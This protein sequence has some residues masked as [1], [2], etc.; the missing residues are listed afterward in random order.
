MIKEKA[1][2]VYH[3]LIRNVSNEYS[4]IVPFIILWI[5]MPVS[6]HRKSCLVFSRSNFSW[7]MC[8]QYFAQIEKYKQLLSLLGPKWFTD[9]VT[10]LTLGSKKKK[11][12]HIFGYIGFKTNIFVPLINCKVVLNFW[13]SFVNNYT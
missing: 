4:L 7:Q 6:I 5:K 3:T 11:K 10:W 9:P 1:S 2:H 8:F 13:L 12:K